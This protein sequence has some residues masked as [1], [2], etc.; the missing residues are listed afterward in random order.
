V[1]LP[2]PD[3]HD[4]LHAEKNSIMKGFI[5][6][7]LLGVGALAF[8]YVGYGHVTAVASTRFDPQKSWRETFS[9]LGDNHRQFKFETHGTARSKSGPL[10]LHID[11]DTANSVANSHRI[12]MPLGGLGSGT[13]SA[14]YSGSLREGNELRVGIQT[15]VQ[16]RYTVLQLKRYSDSWQLELVDES[17]HP[18]DKADAPLPQPRAVQHLSTVLES[19]AE[20]RLGLR[21]DASR[22]YFEAYLNGVAVASRK[23]NWRAGEIVDAFV[24]VGTQSAAL[25][26]N[27]G[28]VEWSPDAGGLSPRGS[29]FADL[30]QGAT[31][32]PLRWHAALSNEPNIERA[33][34]TGEGL[35]MVGSRQPGGRATLDPAIQICTVYSPLTST[36]VDLRVELTTLKFSKSFIALENDIGTRRVEAAF[37]NADENLKMSFTGQRAGQILPDTDVRPVAKGNAEFQVNFDYEP[38][39]Q[40]LHV[41]VNEEEKYA[42]KYGLM[43]GEFTR[44]CVGAYVEI[45]GSFDIRLRRIQAHSA[46]Y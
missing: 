21:F 9:N 15:T 39:S 24:E 18:I 7:A 35:Q 29:T 23:T 3:D 11:C 45:G 34:R 38:W 33:F 28:A 41:R 12:A 32:D 40:R 6:W 10:G 1:C 31:L 42:S 19:E 30:F 8:V 25:N 4:I 17:T 13:F 14:T 43:Q 46:P 20:H 16:A 2:A 5:Y 37:S 36:H 22:G 27:L 26:V 44:L